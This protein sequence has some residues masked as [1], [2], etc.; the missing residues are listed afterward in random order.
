[1]LPTD[2]SVHVYLIK[3]TSPD[4][5]G[6]KTHHFKLTILSLSRASSSH[7]RHHLL[8]SGLVL[9]VHDGSQKIFFYILKSLWGP[10]YFSAKRLLSSRSSVFPNRT[11]TGSTFQCPG[12]WNYQLANCTGCSGGLPLRTTVQCCEFLEV[13][14]LPPPHLTFRRKTNKAVSPNH[15]VCSPFHLEILWP[16]AIRFYFQKIQFCFFL[17][18]GNIMVPHALSCV[19]KTIKGEMQIPHLTC[20]M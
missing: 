12:K 16:C 17:H 14:C 10:S 13:F 11:M 3:E 9:L 8:R 5:I 18:E 20:L 19:N 6:F 7:A 2:P 15:L 4:H 1:M